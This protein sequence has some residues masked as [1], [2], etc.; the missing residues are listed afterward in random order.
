MADFPLRPPRLSLAILLAHPI[1]M[2]V[3]SFNWLLFT[4]NETSLLGATLPQAQIAFNAIGSF[5]FLIIASVLMFWPYRFGSFMLPKSRRNRLLLG[6]A[7]VYTFHVLPCWVIEFSI[8]WN[9]G[10]FAIIQAVSFIYL[11]SLFILESITVWIAYIWHLSG[12]TQNNYGN[13]LFG[14]GSSSS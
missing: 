4:S 9:Y 13:T 8:V 1:A 14:R 11:T 2:A 5:S 3:S 6:T 10:W 12:F 7:I